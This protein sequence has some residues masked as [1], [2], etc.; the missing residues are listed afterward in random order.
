MPV[1]GML[2]MNASHSFLMHLCER[3]LSFSLL[4]AYHKCIAMVRFI[5]TNTTDN[6]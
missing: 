6:F 5:C 3:M 4:Y 2:E 1:I